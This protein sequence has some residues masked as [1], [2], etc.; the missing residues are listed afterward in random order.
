MNFIWASITVIYSHIKSEIE[1]RNNM[2]VAYINSGIQH[3]FFECGASREICKVMFVFL[4]LN[5]YT[6][7][8]T[9]KLYAVK[10]NGMQQKHINQYKSSL[11][12][13]ILHS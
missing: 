2:R 9:K 11:P 8:C 3:G 7:D 10:I 12:V 13:N 5:G 4:D 1:L 6:I